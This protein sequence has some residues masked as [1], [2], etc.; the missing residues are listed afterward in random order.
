[1]DLW[2]VVQKDST[3]RIID[4]GMIFNFSGQK[5]VG[6]KQIKR[7]DQ[8]HTRT[9]LGPAMLLPAA[10]SYVDGLRKNERECVEK[11]CKNYEFLGSRTH[12]GTF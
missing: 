11:L 8:M 9:R 4:R 2:G 1:M 10:C 3:S 6:A 12:I 7:A 5:C